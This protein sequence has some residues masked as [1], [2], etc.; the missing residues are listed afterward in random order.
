MFGPKRD[1]NGE[2]RRLHNEELH[3]SDI[4]KVNKATRFGWAK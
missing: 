2:W 4:V 1:E 3:S